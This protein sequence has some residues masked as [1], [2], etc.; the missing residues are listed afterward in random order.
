MIGKLNLLSS[1]RPL[2]RFFVAF[3]ILRF[4]DCAVA[5]ELSPSFEQPFLYPAPRYAIVIGVESYRRS[6]PRVVNAVNDARA[7]ASTLTKLGFDTVLLEDPDKSSILN[8]LENL[9]N[10]ELRNARAIGAIPFVVFFFAGHGFAAGGSNFLAP[11]T[12]DASDNQALVVSSIDVNQIINRLA[13]PAVLTVILDAC[14]LRI[15][16]L[17]VSA[18]LLQAGFAQESNALG[19]YLI[20]FAAGAGKLARSYAQ[21]GETNSPFTQGL[22][23]HMP[24]YYGP[25]EQTFKNVKAHVEH[26]TKNVSP[27][28]SP[29]AIVTLT[30]DLFFLLP[31]Q[32]EDDMRRIFIDLVAEMRRQKDPRERRELVEAYLK[33]NPLSPFNVYLNAAVPTLIAEGVR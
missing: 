7:M 32:F 24:V 27:R 8:A 15:G 22:T 11:V 6:V 4:A 13:G 25:I 26:L 3:L 10:V 16:D 9:Q 23:A 30:G 21:S 19:E 31:N 5:E 20:A 28:Q 2:S 18:S 12:A 29:F 17:N 14:R 1:R 33:K